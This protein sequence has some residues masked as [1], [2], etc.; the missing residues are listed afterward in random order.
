MDNRRVITR[1]LRFKN[2]GQESLDDLARS[3]KKIAALDLEPASE[4]AR[5][6]LDRYKYTNHRVRFAP[7]ENQV[8]I[9]KAAASGLSISDY[10]RKAALHRVGRAPSPRVAIV[11]LLAVLEAIRKRHP[12]DRETPALV[13]AA[14]RESGGMVDDL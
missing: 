1:N 8:L 3:L 14:I 7:V 10:I 9:E 13:I 12:L 5:D 11:A 6:A 4:I 2:D